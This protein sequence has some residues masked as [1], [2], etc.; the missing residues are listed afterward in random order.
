VVVDYVAVLVNF[1]FD[2]F[3]NFGPVPQQ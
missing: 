1:D 3:W 2:I